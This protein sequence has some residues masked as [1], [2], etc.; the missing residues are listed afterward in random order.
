MSAQGQS[1]NLGFG[2]E[3]HMVMLIEASILPT[4]IAKLA[5]LLAS[6]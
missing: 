5:E 2:T 1:S 6:A 4:C 3:C